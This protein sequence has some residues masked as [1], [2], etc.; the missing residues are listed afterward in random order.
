[1]ARLE[2]SIDVAVP[3]RAAYDQWTQFEEFPHFMDDVVEVR[4]I[5]DTHLHWV[6]DVGGGT[7]EWYAE[8]TEQ[9]P[10]ERVAWESTSGVRNA[11]VVTFHRLSDHLTRIMLQADWGDGDA[12]ASPGE[13]GLARYRVRHD[14]ESFRDFIEERGE[15]TGAWRGDVEAHA[16]DGERALDGLVLPVGR[17]RGAAVVDTS[18][19][20]VGRVVDVYVEPATES[21]RYLGISASWLERGC[22]VVPVEAVDFV[23]G[24]DDEEVLARVPW[25][26]DR[27][28]DTPT[29]DPDDQITRERQLVIMDR[30]DHMDEFTAR[31]RALRARQATPAPT[32][33]IAE[34]ELLAHRPEDVMAE[35]WGV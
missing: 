17:M 9:H 21:V 14:L 7:R 24:D 3:V 4:Q 25:D 12:P 23:M 22:H 2:E 13:M 6:V 10:D 16:V 20:R 1:M 11:G 31:R 34:A 28:K 27:L 30:Y 5:D 29:L 19:E 33:E 32:P 35:R 15:A 18:G 26:R 8:I